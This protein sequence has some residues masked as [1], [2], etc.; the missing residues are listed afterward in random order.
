MCLKCHPRFKD[1]KEHRYWS[2]A[3]KRPCADGRRV[4]RHVL[5][6][7]EINDSQKESWL[8]CID[9]F[10]LDRHEQTRLALF[11]SD[12]PIPEHAAEY[13]VQVRL[14]EFRLH[15]PRQWG[16]CWLFCR[17]WEVLGLNGFWAERLPTSREGTS[18][19][20]VL[21]TLVAYRLIAPGSEWRLHRQW[22][23][24]SAMG[25]LLDE[26]FSLA[27]KDTLYRCLD[28]VL[29]HKEALFSFLTERWRDL[30]GI[31][32]DVLLYDLTS[33]CFESDPP[34]FREDKRRC[35]NSGPAMKHC[36]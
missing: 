30:F 31:R 33:T 22:Y 1:G 11:P 14:G 6:L 34:F 3:E 28:K 13:G 8:R 17:L 19:Y 35:G 27:A 18:W 9:A 12:R 16:A 24:S 29:A 5:Y 32:Y 20:H 10:D 7:G 15:R 25:D 36:C 21:M 23:E 26:D 2:I 4:E